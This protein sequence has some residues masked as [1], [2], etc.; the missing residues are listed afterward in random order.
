MYLKGIFLRNVLKNNP[1]YGP[2]F[3][4]CTSFWSMKK[5]HKLCSGPSNKHSYQDWFQ[6]AQWFQRRKLKCKSLWMTTND[7]NGGEVK[8]IAHLTLWVRWALKGKKPIDRDLFLELKPKTHILFWPNISGSNLK[9]M[10]VQNHVPINL[11]LEKQANYK[12]N[13]IVTV[14]YK[15]LSFFVINHGILFCYIVFDLICFTYLPESHI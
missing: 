14:C 1:T 8:A 7:D 12:T 2:M 10:C 5:N 11:V 3:L 15:R 9:N 13:H 6:L 4:L